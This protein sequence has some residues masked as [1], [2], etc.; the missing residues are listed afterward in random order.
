VVDRTYDWGTDAPPSTPIADSVIYETHVRGITRQHAQV[1]A[2]QRGT[3]AGLASAPVISH[4]TALGVTAVE[5][6]PV[7]QFAPDL[8][9]QPRV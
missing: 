7:H 4:L 8:A 1:P 6:L 9:S 5:L 2:A 3:F